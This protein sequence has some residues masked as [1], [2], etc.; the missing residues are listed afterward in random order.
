MKRLTL[1]AAFVLAGSTAL[2]ACGSSDEPAEEAK[3]AERLVAEGGKL[4]LPAVS[5]RP[6]A[7]YFDITY[8]SGGAPI[9]ESASVEGAEKTEIHATDMKNGAAMMGVAAPIAMFARKTIK[10]EPGGYHLM[11]MD[12]ADSWK[13][14]DSTNVTIKLDN[15]EE[16]TFPVEI[17][18]A[19]DER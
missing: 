2:S 4:V 16:T 13:A 7:V 17:Q 8:N 6:A 3:P 12:P 14:G 10:F 15:G 1:F 19:G 18:A 9:M 5:G 11:V